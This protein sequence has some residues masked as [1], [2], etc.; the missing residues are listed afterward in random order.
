MR[1]FFGGQLSEFTICEL[2]K[3]KFNKIE[4]SIFI[5]NVVLETFMRVVFSFFLEKYAWFY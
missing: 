2:Y 5:K 3:T 1:M 4:D